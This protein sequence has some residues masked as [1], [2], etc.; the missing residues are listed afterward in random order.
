MVNDKQAAIRPS[1]NYKDS[2]SIWNP[3]TGTKREEYSDMTSDH[4]QECLTLREL[5]AALS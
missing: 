3:K 1:D 2:Q 4:T 5:Q